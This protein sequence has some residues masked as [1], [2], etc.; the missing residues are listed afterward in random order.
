MEISGVTSSK[1]LEELLPLN[2]KAIV[3][4][5]TLMR[6]TF[7]AVGATNWPTPLPTA[8]GHAPEPVLR[9]LTAFCYCSGLFSSREIESAARFDANI[10]YLCA[11][12]FPTWQQ[13]WQF[14]RRNIAFFRETLAR[15]FQMVCDEI[16]TPVTFFSC[17]T[18][19]ERRLRLA[20]EADSAAM[21]D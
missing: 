21:D 8:E 20:V 1:R 18:E 5:R 9:T 11:N 3:S 15:L 10:R 14:R 17:V 2:L 16:G 12:D 6:M 4:Q 13:L 19:A 7:E